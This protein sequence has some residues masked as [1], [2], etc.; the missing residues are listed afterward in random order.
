MKLRDRLGLAPK[1]AP[2]AKN[3]KEPVLPSSRTQS[4]PADRSYRS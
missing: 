3:A 1:P 4:T 2:A